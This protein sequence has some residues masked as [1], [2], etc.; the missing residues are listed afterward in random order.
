MSLE[1]ILITQMREGGDQI[2]LA[3]QS[4]GLLESVAKAANTTNA[5]RFHATFVASL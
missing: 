2:T 4:S 3:H 5:A 1:S